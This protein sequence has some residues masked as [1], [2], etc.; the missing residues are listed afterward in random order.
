M[1][2][3]Y[4]NLCSQD[5]SHFSDT[6]PREEATTPTQES[7]MQSNDLSKDYCGVLGTFS[8]NFKI[9]IVDKPVHDQTSDEFLWIMFMILWEC[10]RLFY[11]WPYLERHCEIADLIIRRK[12]CNEY[13]LPSFPKFEMTVGYLELCFSLLRI[14]SLSD[15]T[16]CKRSFLSVRNAAT[17][18]LFAKILNTL[19]LS[20]EHCSKNITIALGKNQPPTEVGQYNNI[21]I[22]QKDS[23]SAFQWF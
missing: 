14:T 11:D 5:R 9:I 20:R 23:V 8:F 4:A 6:I 16:E 7:I 12:Y 22:T 21:I 15:N 19:L 3:D 18:I 17:E 2:R 1:I 10:S 13:Y